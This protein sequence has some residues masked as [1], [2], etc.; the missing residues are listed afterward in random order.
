MPSRNISFRAQQELL[1]KIKSRDPEG[2]EYPGATAKRDVER[3]YAVLEHFS[4]TMESLTPDEAVVLIYY[5]GTYGGRPSHDAVIR[6]GDVLRDSAVG[7]LDEFYDLAQAG[8]G[9]KLRLTSPIGLYVLW[10]AAERYEALAMKAART[11]ES[12]TFGMALHKVGLHT[13]DLAPHVLRRVEATPALESD[14]LPGAYL[15]AAKEDTTDE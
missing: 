6:I 12:L 13:Y 7:F 1:D 2:N 9:A 10:D 5:V 4:R 8:L 15:R 3:W 11:G 14:L